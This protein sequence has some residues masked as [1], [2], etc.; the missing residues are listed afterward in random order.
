MGAQRLWASE[1][2][3]RI[4]RPNRRQPRRGAQRLWAS[5]ELARV[6]EKLHPL[7]AL[8][9]AQRLWASEELALENVGLVGI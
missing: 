9:S 1:E 5:E 4:S 6:S 8:T 7:S 3:A 2:L